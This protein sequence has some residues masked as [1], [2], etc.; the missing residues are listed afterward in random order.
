MCQG[1]FY[2]SNEI[3]AGWYPIGP[4]DAEVWIGDESDK[5]TEQKIEEEV[6]TEQDIENETDVENETNKENK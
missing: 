5:E 4:G 1:R 3:R 6:Q 2:R